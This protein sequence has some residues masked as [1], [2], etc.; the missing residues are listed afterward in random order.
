MPKTKREKE[1]ISESFETL[2]TRFER[3]RKEEPDL[4]KRMAGLVPFVLEVVQG[5]G[6]VKQ[7]EQLIHYSSDQES[8]AE[9]IEAILP[10]LANLTRD[11]PGL[12]KDIAL[13]AEKLARN[14][15]TVPG[16]SPYEAIRDALAKN[17]FM[18]LDNTPW[19]TAVLQ[20]G[21]AKGQAQLKPAMLDEQPLMPPEEVEKW[22][23]LMWKQREELSDLDADTLDMLSHVWLQ[24]A[25]SADNYAVASVDDF[26]Q[27]RG[28]K[29][30]RGGGGRRGGYEPEQRTDMLKA[31]AHIQNLWLNMGEVEVNEETG[32][33]KKMNRSS[34]QA[35]Q[36]R[37]FV[38]T[39][40]MGQTRLDGH[41]D[42][43]RFAFRPG[44]LFARFLFGPG[45]QTALLSA[46]AVQYD[47]Y[48]QKWEKRL[49]RYFSWQWRV[50][51][52]LGDYNKPYQVQALLEAV[53]EELNIRYP[54]KTRERLEKAL[55][56]LKEDGV[57]AGWE[58]EKW[59][60]QIV[61]QR[62]WAEIWQE[63]TI[64]IIPP[65]A[66]RD[67]YRFLKRHG[68]ENAGLDQAFNDGGGMA[69]IVRKTRKDRK[70]SQAQAARELGV[71]QSYLSKLE[72][73]Q[74]ELSNAFRKRLEEWLSGKN[75]DQKL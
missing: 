74:V 31:L 51:A 7:I 13:L 57:I 15:I 16:I 30:K 21:E 49:A 58:Y 46:K 43:Q 50:R 42:V 61:E 66:I 47:P 60:E 9:L 14:N 19:P 67:T 28:L 63:A 40:R 59:E 6:G 65:Q 36:S 56:T 52:R 18:Q 69:E 26:L 20:E 48:R 70:L 17:T 39:D 34:K 27:M 23:A 8:A 64:L 5:S 38:I 35:V 54:A 44:I 45:R 71:T 37:A 1:D 3:L 24:Q 75:Y 73:N 41:M 29:P 10:I 32:K 2:L 11:V 62:G 22:S 72:T 53:G 55:E 33:K 25:N 4:P 68:D 12:E